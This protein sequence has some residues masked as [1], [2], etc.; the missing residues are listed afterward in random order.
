MLSGSRWTTREYQ[1]RHPSIVLCRAKKLGRTI[2][3][4]MLAARSTETG[5]KRLFRIS[6]ASRN[7]FCRINIS[8][9]YDR[10]LGHGPCFVGRNDCDEST[11]LDGTCSLLH[12]V[13]LAHETLSPVFPVAID[14]PPGVLSFRDQKPARDSQS[15]SNRIKMTLSPEKRSLF[16]ETNFSGFV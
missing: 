13:Y 15:P 11:P 4:L 9:R 8:I 3:A 16:L 10:R 1:P 6:S 12:S 14:Q 7:F 5:G 2:K